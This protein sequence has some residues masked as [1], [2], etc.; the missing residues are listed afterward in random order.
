MARVILSLFALFLITAPAFPLE[1]GG[2]LTKSPKADYT[3][4]ELDQYWGGVIA[5]VMIQCGDFL[6]GK[7]LKDLVKHYDAAKYGMNQFPLSGRLR[8][9]V[10]TR[11]RSYYSEYLEH[12]KSINSSAA[13]PKSSNNNKRAYM[14]AW[15]DGRIC[16]G[17]IT[18]QAPFMWRKNQ[19]DY[20]DEAKHRGLTLNKCAN[21]V[22]QKTSD[23]D[24]VEQKA[25]DSDSTSNSNKTRNG[26]ELKHEW[27]GTAITRILKPCGMQSTQ[28][29][30]RYLDGKLVISGKDA[31]GNL[32]EFSG[33]VKPGEGFS[34]QGSWHVATQFTS[35]DYKGAVLKG[36]MNENVIKG[37]IIST[38]P[39][40]SKSCELDFSLVRNSN[41]ELVPGEPSPD[42]PVL[43]EL[44]L[45][46]PALDELDLE[47]KLRKIKY[48][49]DQEL[50][51]EEEAAEK[52]RQ[53]LAEF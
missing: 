11:I 18:P 39:Q 9:G 8:A 31:K 45:D 50:I 33:M 47:K 44:V 34:F 22:E 13:T 40:Y 12:F 42:E 30:G 5:N 53:L 36:V 3:D 28:L 16:E 14:E 48:L 19:T 27:S 52:R 35:V 25:S 17:A 49:L 38:K 1:A 29:T 7:E 15:A 10:C 32:N 51:T 2:T 24:L 46:E 41:D 4:E 6:K 20:V 21:L 37:V 43:D 23:S 26:S